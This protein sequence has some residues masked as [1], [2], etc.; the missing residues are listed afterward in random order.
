MYLTHSFVAIKKGELDYLMFYITEDYVEQQV[1]LKE[2]LNPLLEELGRNLLDK[3]AIIKAFDRDV[4]SA[5]KELTEKFDQEFTRDII[6]SF[7]HQMERP[8]LLIL[9]SDINT[10]DPKNHKWLYISFRDFLDE[11][12]GVKIYKLKELFDILVSAIKE[13]KDLFKKAENHL[14][15]QKTISAHKMVELKPGIFGISLDVKETFNFFNQ[16]RNK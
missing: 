13:N 2:Q 16:L 10:F 3:G 4:N 14:K 12:G 11:F 8:G 1:K 5:N 15:K 7:D 6:I 9:N